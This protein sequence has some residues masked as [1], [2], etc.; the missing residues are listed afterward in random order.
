MDLTKNEKEVYK[1][2]EDCM[3]EYGD[4]F[5]DVGIDD[6]VNRTGLNIMTVKGVLGSLM[7]KEIVGAMDV[8]GEYNVY[9]LTEWQ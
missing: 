4:G 2:I 5:S 6:I 8:N 1:V 9:Y 7:K 3:E